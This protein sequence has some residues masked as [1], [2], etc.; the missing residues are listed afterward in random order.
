MNWQ[1]VR[2]GFPYRGYRSSVDR[3]SLPRDM[4]GS[5]SLDLRF[6]PPEGKFLA[7]LGSEVR[8]DT[9]GSLA[10]LCESKFGGKARQIIEFSSA[11]LTDGYPTYFVI[12]TDES[13]KEGYGYFRGNSTGTNNGLGRF[14]D[15]TNH[16][17]AAGKDLSLFE[18]KWTPHWSEHATHVQGRGVSIGQRETLV[19]GTR[20]A[21]GVG[22]WLFFPCVQGNPK[23]WNRRFND[24]TGSGTEPD[25]LRQWGIDPPC[26]L[27]RFV[28]ASLTALATTSVRPWKEGQSF[29]VTMTFV[30]EDGSESRPFIPRADLSVSNRT[31][32]YATIYGKVTIPSAGGSTDY[33]PYLPLTALVIGPP[34]TKERRLYRTPKTAD[35]TT[36]P[37]LSEFRLWE[38]IPDNTSTTWKSY[39]GDDESLLSLDPLDPEGATARLFA[40]AWPKRGRYAWAAD[41]SV[42]V[43]Y[44]KDN[45]AA[46]VLVPTGQPAGPTTTSRLQNIDDNT[47]SP[48]NW[49]FYR[50]YDNSGT[51][52]LQ[53]RYLS[54][55]PGD[56]T[57]TTTAITLTSSKTL[58]D[59]VDEINATTSAGAGG[60]WA[61]TLAPG[62]D[63][64]L[65]STLIDY[66]SSYSYGDDSASLVSDGTTGNVRVW[67]NA[68]GG[69]LYLTQAQAN[70][71]TYKDAFIH[72]EAGP[73]QKALGVYSSAL[74][75]YINGPGWM[76][77]PP[78][79]AG[80]LM[81]GAPVDRGSI[82]F[83]SK[84]VWSYLRGG[85]DGLSEPNK[86]RLQKISD[87]GCIAWNS[88]THGNGWVGWLSREGYCVTDGRPDGEVIISGDLW[89][90]EKGTGDLSYE[91]GQCVAAAAADSDGAYFAAKVLGNAHYLSYR[92]TSAA[93]YPN[94]LFEYS[95]ADT[96]GNSG[97]AQVLR[98]DGQPYGWSTP[99]RL[100]YAALGSVLRETTPALWKLGAVD[101]GDTGHS[102]GSGRVD[103]FDTSINDPGSAAIT[104]VGY[105]RID[106]FGA[107]GRRS[108]MRRFR[109][110]HANA[111]NGVTITLYR[112]VAGSTSATFTAASSGTDP[113]IFDT[114]RVKLAAQVPSRVYSFAV[115]SDG[116][117]TAGV[118]LFGHEAEVRVLKTPVELD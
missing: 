71:N 14:Y 46:I 41:G 54:A 79:D 44:L 83:Y 109:S 37:S 106:D 116:L 92:A 112:D 68:W 20:R 108:R 34:G 81:G 52:T 77:R 53:L 102:T 85:V 7:R 95:F 23:M 72:T 61:A 25:R 101:D 56:P 70:V 103:R 27:P 5:G 28:T 63:G 32:E 59:V 12:F 49:F 69:T 88:I 31:D 91:V 113:F 40:I 24:A 18:H 3:N 21:I 96:A 29:F 13:D 47:A 100:G 74:T 66:T 110:K 104:P 42:F 2:Y 22:N 84:S 94:R 36:E 98:K 48:Y 1:R 73:A 55:V 16:Y 62:A 45:P 67:S 35:G 117:G 38:V 111:G 17:P 107:T 43:G 9:A 33:Y 30:F 19:A 65:L 78:E 99:W 57:T 51:K 50:I 76:V 8:E 80:I 90:S 6:S 97:L 10:G 26:F 15:T 60:E 39:N 4:L 105:H 86:Y 82:V 114:K 118:E 11:S 115:S 93:T 75:F 64:S 58:N 89:E 87:K